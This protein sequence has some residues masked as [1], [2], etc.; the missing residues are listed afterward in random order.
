MAKNRKGGGRIGAV[1]GRT[2]FQLPN[3]HYAKRDTTTGVILSVKADL[4][5]Y[6]G[7]VKEKQL[8]QSLPD[9]TVASPVARGRRA[10]F[11]P[12]RAWEWS[13]RRHTHGDRFAALPETDSAR[14]TGH[15]HHG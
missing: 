13:I 2:Q 11:P 8:Q 7:I 15:L 5:P 14:S 4:K 9:T 1:R 12:L 10:A 3:G 6:K